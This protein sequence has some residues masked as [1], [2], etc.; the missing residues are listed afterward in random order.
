MHQRARQLESRWLFVCYQYAMTTDYAIRDTGAILSPS[1]LFYEELIHRNIS[2]AIQ[3]AGDSNRL[4]PHVKTHKTREIVRMEMAL[5]VTRHKAATIAE[6]EML[7]G[8]GVPDVLLAYPMVGPNCARLALLAVRFP[9]CRFSTIIDDLGCARQLSSAMVGVGVEL[10]VLIDLDCGQHRT[11]IAPGPDAIALYE[12]LDGLPGILP[13][14]IHAYDGHLHI[15]NLAVR[16][17]SVQRVLDSVLGLRDSVVKKGLPVPHVVLA[18]T[19]TFPLYARLD[20]PGL[21]CCPGTCVLYDHGYA[22]RFPDLPGFVPAALLL[23]RVVSRP[24][25]TR[26]TLDLGTKALASDPPA[27]E[28]CLLLGVPEYRPVAH[29]EEHLVV[30]MPASRLRPGDHLFAIPTHVCPTC[31]LYRH[32]YVVRAGSVVGRWEIVARDRQLSI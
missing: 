13:A 16:H 10:D 31:A 8:C 1:L 25:P 20:V 29:N 12:S 21:E 14:G 9:G 17:D 18:G 11:G 23:T 5:G 4:R 32:A 26:V 15:P 6:A 30:E 24:T 3:I 27:G 19:P 28:R 7:A 22:S 2:Q